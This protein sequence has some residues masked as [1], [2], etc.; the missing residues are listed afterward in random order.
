MVV[1]VLRKCPMPTD[2][3][4]TKKIMSGIFLS[5]QYKKAR[6]SLM[7]TAMFWSCGCLQSPKLRKL[8]QST[9]GN[10]FLLT[11]STLTLAIA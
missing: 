7:A 6:H 9:V 4:A 5:S 2:E 11:A 10:F 8:H 3:Q 1:V